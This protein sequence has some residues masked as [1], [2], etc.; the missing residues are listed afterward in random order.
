MVIEE[1]RKADRFS[2]VE[3]ISG[4]FGAAEVSVVNLSISGAQISHSQPIRI[5]TVARLAFSRG[6]AVVA[7]SARVL[8]SHVAPS[9]NGK[10]SY[11]SGL[12]LE[13]ADAQYALA[14]NTLIRSGAIRQDLDSMDRKRKREEE[15][16]AKK[17]SGPKM[18]PVSEPPPA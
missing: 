8:W 12:K 16:E 10:L 5:G 7:I 17:K 1:L 9:A 4:T 18:I 2:A 13:G 6:D 11:R 3:S 14:L 15:R